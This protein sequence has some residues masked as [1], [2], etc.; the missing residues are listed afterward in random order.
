[1]MNSVDPIVTTSGWFAVRCVF[2][3]GWPEPSPDDPPG[4]DYEERIT[5]WRAS[6]AE[7]AI[8][9]AEA[10]AQDYASTIEEAPSEFLG[11]SQ[12]YELFDNPEDG[13]EVFSLIRRSV[14]NP[15]D[16][17]TAFF[18]TGDERQADTSDG[19]SRGTD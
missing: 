14:L 11:L 8:A 3:S 19:S 2:R 12:S 17:L 9:K 6:S 16:Y 13:A 5:L 10:E 4:H 18:D 7:E 1:M 15:E